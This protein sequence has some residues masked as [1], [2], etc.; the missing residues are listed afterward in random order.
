MDAWIESIDFLVVQKI[1]KRVRLKM[2]QIQNNNFFFISA[3]QDFED[4][5]SRWSYHGCTTTCCVE[6]AIR[7]TDKIQKMLR[8]LTKNA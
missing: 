4:A 5:E 8:K 3:L 2:G 1:F 6:N 7:M